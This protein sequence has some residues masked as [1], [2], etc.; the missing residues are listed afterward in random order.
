MKNIYIYLSLSSLP[1]PE[2]VEEVSIYDV[3]WETS[4]RVADETLDT[5]FL[6]GMYSRRLPA[7]CYADF[8]HQEMLYLDRVITMLQVK[9]KY[10]K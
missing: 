7:H 9:R 4:E 5:A 2:L 8:C 3:L 1:P 10:I 6:R